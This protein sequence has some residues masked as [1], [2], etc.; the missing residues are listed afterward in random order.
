MHLKY[1]K[2]RTYCIARNFWGIKFS[3]FPAIHE[4]QIWKAYGKVIA[5]CAHTISRGCEHSGWHP[6]LCIHTLM[7]KKDLQNGVCYWADLILKT[8]N[9]PTISSLEYNWVLPILPLLQ[10]TDHDGNSFPIAAHQISV[11]IW[12]PLTIDHI[13]DHICHLS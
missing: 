11:Y 4:N 6:S 2:E 9:T 13:L 12:Q 8:S 10:Q 5:T 3:H 7:L 1:H